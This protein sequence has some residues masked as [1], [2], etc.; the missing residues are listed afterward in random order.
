VTS[1]SR[2]GTLWSYLLDGVHLFAR[3]DDLHGFLPKHSR[4]LSDESL[5]MK[6]NFTKFACG[7][8]GVVFFGASGWSLWVSPRELDPVARTPR[9]LLGRNV[10]ITSGSFS[11]DGKRIVTACEGEATRIWDAPSGRQMVQSCAGTT[12]TG[13]R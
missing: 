6:R 4:D 9:I 3:N 10:S 8:A 13:L 12:V 5:R 11:P 7:C 2:F 1:A